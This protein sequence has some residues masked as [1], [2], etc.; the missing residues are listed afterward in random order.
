MEE[1]DFRNMT[2]EK[3]LEYLRR[4]IEALLK[5]SESEMLSQYGK[6]ILAG[7]YQTARWTVDPALWAD[8]IWT[9]PGMRNVYDSSEMGKE[10][11]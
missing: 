10:A 1:K 3:R 7:I 6:G 2:I 8:P 11:Q 4:E 5:S 9:I